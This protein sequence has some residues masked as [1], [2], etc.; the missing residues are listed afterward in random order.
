MQKVF[1]PLVSSGNLGQFKEK[2]RDVYI[3][4]FFSK[5]LGKLGHSLDLA[6][7]HLMG[8]IHQ[9]R[10]HGDKREALRTKF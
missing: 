10:E 6:Q 8:R 7:S 9:I 2:R 3:S 5:G 4:P 1:I